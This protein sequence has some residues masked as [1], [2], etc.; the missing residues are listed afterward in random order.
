[1]PLGCEE[2]G[3]CIS[4]IL[5]SDGCVWKPWDCTSAQTTAQDLKSQ[6]FMF[7]VHCKRV[8]NLGFT[9]PGI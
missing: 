5:H 1:M 7:H 9:G 6:V 4:L 3:G 2:L 8:K